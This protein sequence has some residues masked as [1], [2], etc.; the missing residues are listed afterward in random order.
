MK[1]GDIY[2]SLLDGAKY[3]VKRIVNEKGRQANHNWS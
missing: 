1:E 3:V 2:E